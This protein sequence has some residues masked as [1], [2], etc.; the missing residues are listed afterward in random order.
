MPWPPASVRHQP[1][2]ELGARV[3]RYRHNL[4]VS[5]EKLAEQCGLSRNYVSDVERG[6]R[7]ITLYNLVRI[8]HALEVDPGL[9]VTGL[10][11]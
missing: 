7:N 6:Q 9:L 2:Q 11:P 8:A 1:A 10:Q 3:R 4:G 5:Q